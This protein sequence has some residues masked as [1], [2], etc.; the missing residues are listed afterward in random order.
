MENFPPVNSHLT[1]P[2]LQPNED[3]TEEY[4]GLTTTSSIAYYSCSRIYATNGTE[5]LVGC[6]GG[7]G[8]AGG[9]GI[10]LVN[11][12]NQNTQE[13]A[14]CLSN[15]KYSKRCFNDSGMV[16]KQEFN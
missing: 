2:P 16:Y 9:S 13:K 10:F 7:D 14:F 6:G 3:R 11:L 8:P 12:S 15:P 5:A 1:L 4:S